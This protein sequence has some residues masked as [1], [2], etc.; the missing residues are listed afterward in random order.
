[1]FDSSRDL[2]EYSLLERRGAR[3]EILR[4]TRKPKV[5]NTESVNVMV[6]GYVHFAK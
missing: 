6:D 2:G 5:P 3:I 4:S 1:M